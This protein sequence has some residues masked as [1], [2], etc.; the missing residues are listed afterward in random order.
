VIDLGFELILTLSFGWE[1]AEDP[2]MIMKMEPRKHITN[3]IAIKN[4]ERSRQ[5]EQLKLASSHMSLHKSHGDLSDSAYLLH[6]DE[7]YLD[8]SNEAT[9]AAATQS[10]RLKG[11][12][13]TYFG[14]LKQ[15][16]SDR[17]YWK[18]FF[19]SMKDIVH[20]TDEK[21]VDSRVLLWSYVEGGG[22][23][24]FG[25]LFTFFAVL[26]IEFGI[27][28][29]VARQGQIRGGMYWKPHS[30]DLIREDG[31]RVVRFSLLRKSNTC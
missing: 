23:E 15:F 18:S 17:Q 14:E 31:S 3:E 20:A 26:W 12:M 2:D 19:Y 1:P 27:S 29:T 25:A 30:P 28:P 5:L 7:E 6:N 21:L 13:R 10:R 22:I 16:L 24:C 4:F 9:T 8:D 11:R